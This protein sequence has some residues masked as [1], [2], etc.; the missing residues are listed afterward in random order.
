MHV[1]V[2]SMHA[3]N[4]DTMAF[5]SVHWAASTASS[6]SISFGESE[7]EVSDEPSVSS[8]LAFMAVVLISVSC[9]VFARTASD[10]KRPAPPLGSFSKIWS[11]DQLASG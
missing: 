2:S 4:L 10:V 1:G 3:C 5:G 9:S 11:H 8:G 7:D 6:S